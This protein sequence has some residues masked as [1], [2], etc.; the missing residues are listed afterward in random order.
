MQNCGALPGELRSF[1]QGLGESR[2]NLVGFSLGGA[3]LGYFGWGA[4]G[5]ADVG[6]DVPCRPCP[7]VLR[8]LRAFGA[9][10]RGCGH[11]LCAPLS[12][13]S[14]RAQKV[15]VGPRWTGADGADED[16]CPECSEVRRMVAISPAGF[17]PKVP[18]LYYLLRARSS[19]VFRCFSL[20][21]AR[22]ELLVA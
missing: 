6:L 1:D 21:C 3:F 8:A 12:S 2:V 11:G 16:G 10:P 14:R 17:V 5:V 22:A 9:S 19:A 20:R 15:L 13:S 7:A 18:K 4:G